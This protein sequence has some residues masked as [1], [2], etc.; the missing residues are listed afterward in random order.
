MSDPSS[1]GGTAGDRARALGW[2]LSRPARERIRAVRRTLADAAFRHLSH[3]PSRVRL[4]PRPTSDPVPSELLDPGAPIPESVRLVAAAVA[5]P[6]CVEADVGLP[7]DGSTAAGGLPDSSAFRLHA[8]PADLAPPDRSAVVAT[9]VSRVRD[10]GATADEDLGPVRRLGPWWVRADAAAGRV[11]RVPWREPHRALADLPPLPGPP[12]VLLLSPHLAVGGAERLL[13]DLLRGLGDAVRPILVTTEP[14]VRS[15]GSTLDQAR[16]LTDRVFTLGDWLPRELHSSAVLHLVRRFSV[17]TLVSWNGTVLFY[18]EVDRWRRAAPG[19]RIVHQVFADRGGWMARTGSRVDRSVDVHL[20]VNRETAA[21]FRRFAPEG[22]VRTVHHGVPLPP[23][24]DPETRERR[25]R[26]AR[27]AL[28][29]AE[30]GLWAG[31]FLRL[32]PQKRP[33]DLVET[34]RRLSDSPWRVLVAG[35]GPLESDVDRAAAGLRPGRFVRLPFQRDV[36]TL[37]DAVDL[38]VSPSA[39]EGLPVLLLDAAARGIP[40]VATAVGDVPL[41]LADGGGRLV[42]RPGDLDAFTE[43]VRQ[44]SDDSVREEEGRRARHSVEAR[45][46]LDRYVR[47]LRECLLP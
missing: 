40:V 44:L 13:Y 2:E 39:Y 29:V 10:G 16:T 11:H 45:F 35:G 42:D 9:T 28:G 26:E 34:A 33:L 24:P 30:D 6:G 25:R 38:V 8:F 37:Y 18:D 41:L 7:E 31:A 1:R 32:H 46:G 36:D 17:R 12:S 19:L 5:L 15:L 47:E 22:R 20:A 3:G 14:H 21:A 43:A 23:L 27:R 4:A